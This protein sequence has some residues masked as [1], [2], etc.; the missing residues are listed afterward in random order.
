M[1]PG[2]DTTGE[3]MRGWATR[4][5][6]GR[7]WGALAVCAAAIFSAGAAAAAERGVER[8]APSP[9]SP[10]AEEIRRGEILVFPVQLAAGDYLRVVLTQAGGDLATTLVGP[11][12]AAVATT[13]TAS[14]GDPAPAS[15]VAAVAGVHRIEIRLVAGHARASFHLGLEG[16]RAATEDDARRA[17]ADALLAEGDRA[18]RDGAPGLALARER[19][20]GARL[21][22]HALGASGDEA[23]AWSRACGLLERT[24]DSPGWLACA[25]KEIDLWRGAGNA[26]REAEA[27]TDVA[28]AHHDQGDDRAA[29]EGFE[30][31]LPL[32]RVAGDRVGEAE[33]LAGI[34]TAL[35]ALGDHRSAISRAT[36][37][38]AI[39]R[40]VGYSNGEA[41]T[42]N[43]RAAE[44][45]QVGEPERG[46]ADHRRALAIFESLHE[47][48]GVGMTLAFLGRL[49]Q[50]QGRPRAALAA[51]ERAQ[52]IFRRVG[53]RRFEGHVLEVMGSALTALGRP[54]EARSR[55]R[56]ALALAR[57]EGDRRSQA[58][59]EVGDG[60]AALADGEVGAS[61]GVSQK[62]LALA[63]EV[64]DP[65]LTA[66]ALVQL[67]RAERAAGEL[68]PAR[69]HLEEALGI[70]E[71]LRGAMA[72]VD[73][74]ASYLATNHARY[75]LLVDLL[76]ELEARHP[77]EGYATRAFEVSDRARARGLVELLAE[78]RADIQQGIA[79][80]LLAES[81]EVE[82]E[83]DARAQALA[84]APARARA[85][86][87][88]ALDKVSA[89]YR[90]LQSEIRARSPRYAELTQP[91][92]LDAEAVQ[93][94]L[95]DGDTVLLEYAL[96]EDRSFLWVVSTSGVTAHQLPRRTV[97]EGAVRR[98][99]QRWS[100]PGAASAGVAPAE[101]ALAR[102]LLGP[103]GPTLRA[104]RWLIVGDGALLYLPFAALPAGAAGRVADGHEVVSL[105]S[106]GALVALRQEADERE[107]P[108]HT[109][110]VLA[111]P[112]F[113][114]DD[115][116]VHRAAG[117]PAREVQLASAA[118]TRSQADAGI[119][120]LERLA[121]SRL[122]AQAIAALVPPGERLEALDFAASRETAL[123]PELGRY[124]FVHF[125]SHALIDAR[126]PELSGIVLSL[127][128]RAG[129]PTPGFLQAHE[130]YNL[131]LS[132]DLVVLS[133]CETALGKE[134]R[135]EGLVG[136]ARAFM[137]AGAPRVL[138]SLW[139]VQ[140]L[141]TAELMRRF[142]RAMLHDGLSP[143]AALRATQAS[144][145][146][147]GRWSD[148]NDWA[149]FVLIGDWH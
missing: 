82:A 27:I 19:F 149:G 135:G 114:P 43:N 120:A 146:R 55:L 71:T 62:A 79:P 60:L 138:A 25:T 23:A 59:V 98:V 92:A 118:L 78:A 89:R 15:L 33:T 87:A 4:H 102:M 56:A 123:G 7:P 34:G 107:V 58:S 16:P 53:D 109:L 14:D 72:G 103:A 45:V 40:G 21:A 147:S 84:R 61:L 122:E 97:V 57:E 3:P 76:M 69:S 86:L 63:R 113:S 64:Q 9:G 112:V 129:R 70:T 51:L 139:K 77:G 132:A 1:D 145:A 20:E 26:R 99:Y 37:A 134:V 2:Q 50:S 31:A 140:D 65:G 126:H 93:R 54:A 125:A 108:V 111:D 35:G 137:Y 148:P 94:E 131:H 68:E 96:G 13:Q 144:M 28:T 90:D 74:R 38:L 17:A 29:L 6:V 85:G 100:T 106:V 121:G 46:L 124:R 133:G 47:P 128:D 48:R 101:A 110:A 10:E 104:R 143:A 81:R 88:D 32:R 95:L 42:L 83:L 67:S 11:G 5:G 136:M 119:A 73:P 44:Y 24:G 80:E 116:R 30:A 49:D 12:G 52:A 142:Y 127:V 66:R 105:P 117:R 75:E 115:P 141:A 91:P 39:L 22:Y 130:L 18:A 36:E 41:F 8:P